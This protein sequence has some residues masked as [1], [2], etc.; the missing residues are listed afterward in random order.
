GELHY[1]RNAVTS[2]QPHRATHGV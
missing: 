1:R 2:K